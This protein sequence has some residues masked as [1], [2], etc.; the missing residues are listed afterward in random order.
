MNG[1]QNRSILTGNGAGTFV[2][3]GVSTDALARRLRLRFVLFDAIPAFA[4]SRSAISRNC[5]TGHISLACAANSV[6]YVHYTLVR[7]E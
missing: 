3:V 5:L 2:L 1:F 6:R 7:E 4:G